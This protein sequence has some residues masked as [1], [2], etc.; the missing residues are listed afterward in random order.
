MSATILPTC[1]A[2]RVSLGLSELSDIDIISFGEPGRIS[3]AVESTDFTTIVFTLPHII[4]PKFTSQL[5]IRKHRTHVWRHRECLKPAIAVSMHGNTAERLIRFAVTSTNNLKTRYMLLN[6]AA[7]RC[8]PCQFTSKP[9]RKTLM[10]CK[11][12]RIKAF[13][14]PPWEFAF[15]LSYYANTADHMT[16]SDLKRKSKIAAVIMKWFLQ[17]IP[18]ICGNVGTYKHFWILR[19]SYE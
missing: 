18:C 1:Y 16:K 15:P 14:L 8:Y 5:P 11:N 17:G 2:L 12:Q 4:S 19:S 9:P 3:Q 10:S 6:F 7:W 13:G